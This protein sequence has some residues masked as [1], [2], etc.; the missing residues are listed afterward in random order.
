MSVLEAILK[1]IATKAP[2]GD[3]KAALTIISIAHKE[4]LLTPEQE[5]AVEENL[6]ENEKAILSDLKRR[7]SD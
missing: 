7:L 4:G 5:E 3:N 2:T 1:T 6:T